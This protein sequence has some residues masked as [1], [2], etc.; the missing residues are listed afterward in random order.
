M[1]YNFNVSFAIIFL[2]QGVSG[3]LYKGKHNA[4]KSVSVERL[5]CTHRSAQKL[6]ANST[7]VLARVQHWVLYVRQ[8]LTEKVS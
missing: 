4:T 8:L 7:V 2:L 5:K 3:N 6:C 1:F